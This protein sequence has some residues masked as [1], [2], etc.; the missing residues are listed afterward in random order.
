MQAPIVRSGRDRARLCDAAALHGEPA[1]EIDKVKGGWVVRWDH[2][3]AIWP[4][5]EAA[6]LNRLTI[7]LLKTRRATTGTK[8]PCDYWSLYPLRDIDEAC[9][10][11]A[12]LN[13][14]WH[15]NPCGAVRAVEV[16]E[17]REDPVSLGLDPEVG[18]PDWLAAA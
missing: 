12:I 8:A 2:H 15:G 13:E 4:Q 9:T 18:Y 10:V 6:L 1:C 5:R 16:L 3:A 17:G 11:W 14:C 7:N